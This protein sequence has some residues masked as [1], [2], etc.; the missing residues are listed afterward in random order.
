MHAGNFITN[1]V[2]EYSKVDDVKVHF[3]F[4]FFKFLLLFQ[5]FKE[6]MTYL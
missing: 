3:L 5:Y 1:V 2:M 4:F 6:V